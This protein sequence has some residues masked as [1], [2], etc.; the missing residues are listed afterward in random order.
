VK[1]ATANV[2]PTLRLEQ[3]DARGVWGIGGH[4]FW[5]DQSWLD[6]AGGKRI[7]AF[8]PNAAAPPTQAVPAKSSRHVERRIIS[9]SL[10]PADW[11]WTTISAVPAAGARLAVPERSRIAGSGRAQ[12]F[13]GLAHDPWPR[14]WRGQRRAGRRVDGGW[15]SSAGTES[16]PSV[17][18]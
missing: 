8:N 13:A 9:A 10:L 3:T 4:P 12:V 7:R 5:F 16:V 2:C 18:D 11:K 17:A 1:Y 14:A 15:A 6:H